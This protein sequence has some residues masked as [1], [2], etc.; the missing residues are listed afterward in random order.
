MPKTNHLGRKV[1][2]GVF[3]PPW[4]ALVNKQGRRFIDETQ[5][6]LISGFLLNQQT[7]QIAYAIYDE[8]AVREA[9]AD[10]SWT[11]PYGS[12]VSVPAWEEETLRKKIADGA[13]K[14]ADTLAELAGQI[15]IDPAALEFT[16]DAYNAD[17]AEGL[18]RAFLKDTHLRFPVSTPPFYAS[19]IRACVIGNTNA[20]LD[21]DRQC[22]VLDAAER[23]I[24]G[25][26]AAGEVLGCVQGRLY[27][28]G[29]LG[30]GGAII[31]G[32]HVGELI[33]EQVRRAAAV[34]A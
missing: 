21:I 4:I 34:P 2:E 11:D 32:R 13:I 15:G 25:L 12:G 5:P 7:D 10:A 6:Y 26:Y 3:L 28:A 18:D 17:C 1:L 24:P 27:N 8:R 20:G 22:R 19:E 14:R 9:T 31:W 30:I 16:L 23:P 29:G 33:G